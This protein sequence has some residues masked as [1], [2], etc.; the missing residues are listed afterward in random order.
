MAHEPIAAV[1][2]SLNDLLKSKS[3]G[4]RLAVQRSAGLTI[5]P[6]A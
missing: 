5:A 3:R 4:R 6:P 2:K 1:G